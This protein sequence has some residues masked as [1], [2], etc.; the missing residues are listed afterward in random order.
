MTTEFYCEICGAPMVLDPEH[1]FKTRKKPGTMYRVRRFKCT[2]CDFAETI[3]G[4]GTADK[5]AI[6]EQGIDQMKA[7]Y[8]QEEINRET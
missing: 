3:F 8:K 2:L 5:K 7:I 1:K 6:P 4:D